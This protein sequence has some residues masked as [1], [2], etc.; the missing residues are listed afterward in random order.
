MTD[1]RVRGAKP[2]MKFM[3]LGAVSVSLSLSACL[4]PLENGGAIDVGSSGASSDS[5]EDST[6]TSGVSTSGTTEAAVTD[7]D[8]DLEDQAALLCSTECL[9]GDTC[10]WGASCGTLNRRELPNGEISPT[11]D[12][13]LD[14][15]NLQA[16]ECIQAA[17]E[18]G[19]PV[20]YESLFVGES[21]ANNRILRLRPDGILV[22]ERTNTADSCDNVVFGRSLGR[23][24]I[25]PSECLEGEPVNAFYCLYDLDLFGSAWTCIEANDCN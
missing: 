17:I 10:D 1:R 11:G 15:D 23:P 12:T 14:A 20:S 22:T 18:A 13:D 5:T 25:D 4:A 2:D 9:D 7:S 16:V 8:G 6:E 24:R 21:S 3:W 19:L